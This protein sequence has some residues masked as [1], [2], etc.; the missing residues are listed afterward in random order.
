MEVWKDSV[1]AQTSR[2]KRPAYEYFPLGT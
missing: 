2:A 1:T